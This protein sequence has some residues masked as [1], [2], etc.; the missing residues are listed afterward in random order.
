MTTS[1]FLQILCAICGIGMLVGIAL[2]DE[3][4]F[5]KVVLAVLVICVTTPAFLAAGIVI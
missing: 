5:A 4:R 3:G 1:L 2:I